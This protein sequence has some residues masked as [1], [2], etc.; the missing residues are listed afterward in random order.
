[1]ALRISEAMH[2]WYVVHSLTQALYIA[3]VTNI[4]VSHW[5]DYGNAIAY[6][7]NHANVDRLRLL[8]EVA[9]GMCHTIRV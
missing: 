6:V 4:Q 9:S 5:M 1:M 7:Q 3:E 8:S 2:T